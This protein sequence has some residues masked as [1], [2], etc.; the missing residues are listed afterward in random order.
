[1]ANFNKVI[2]IGNLTR[3]PELRFSSSGLAICSFT[4]AVNSKIKDKEDEVLFIDIVAF[5]KSAEAIEKYA[6]R[7]D[8]LMVEGRL[9]TDIWTDKEGEKRKKTQVILSSFQFL[10]Q[11]NKQG[12]LD[13]PPV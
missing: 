11:K 7:G 2:L 1:M 4:L 13:E 8:P 9:K 6:H 10:G 3:D 5:G 12:D